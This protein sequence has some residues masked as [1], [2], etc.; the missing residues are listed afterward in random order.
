MILNLI[1]NKL[2]SLI[3]LFVNLFRR[4]LCCFRRRKMS[5][6]AVPLTHVISSSDTDERI[7]DGQNW[8]DWED[9]SEPKT[10]QDHI[11]MYRKRKAQ[12]ITGPQEPPSIESQLNFFED[13]APNITKQTKVFLNTKQ[14]DDS[15]MGLNRLN[16]S[17]E[18]LQ[19]VVSIFQV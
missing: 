15:R 4:A 9:S 1:F 10:V 19:A 11:E 2:K 7:R 5:C 14:N 13:M 18:A 12:I 8:G 17:E 16:F 3:L 6:D